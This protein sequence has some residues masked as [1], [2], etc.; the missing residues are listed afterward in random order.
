MGTVCEPAD[1]KDATP[2]AYN[3][4]SGKRIKAPL[5][6]IKLQNLSCSGY[7]SSST[8]DSDNC[9]PRNDNGLLKMSEKGSKKLI[10]HGFIGESQED[11]L[12]ETSVTTRVK[13]GME[14]NLKGACIA[15]RVNNIIGGRQ[16]EAPPDGNEIKDSSSDNYSLSTT[17]IDN[18]YKL[19]NV[20][21][22]STGNALVTKN[23]Y[24]TNNLSTVAGTSQSIMYSIDLGP[25][26]SVSDLDSD[27]DDILCFN[28][29]NF[30]DTKKLEKEHATNTV[31]TPIAGI[32]D[33]GDER[34]TIEV[35]SLLNQTEF[36]HILCQQEQNSGDR[37]YDSD[38]LL[39][40]GNTDTGDTL[41]VTTLYDYGSAKRRPT[42]S[43][44]S[45]PTDS[46][47]DTP[48][49]SLTGNFST[50]YHNGTIIPNKII[51]SSRTDE[52]LIYEAEMADSYFN[53]TIVGTKSNN[54]IANNFKVLSSDAASK[55][56]IH[57]EDITKTISESAGNALK[58]YLNQCESS[59]MF[60]YSKEEAS[61]VN[62]TT[63][64]RD[65]LIHDQ[66]VK[67]KNGFIDESK[68]NRD[69]GRRI[70]SRYMNKIY[71][72]YGN[73][74]ED[75]F[76]LCIESYFILLWLMFCWF[77]F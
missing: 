66:F 56:D 33:N 9:T 55:K 3:R 4:I 69:I 68:Y 23:L 51:S 18:V 45:V 64:L 67:V 49:S 65:P 6:G 75:T 59:R 70:W 48:T 57:G 76:K 25:P 74:E 11:K 17:T 47:I 42:G 38:V 73:I 60:L 22:N 20:E 1:N 40:T 21:I 34:H 7:I 2:Q 31:T 39:E 15:P 12:S 14:L 24:N 36:N 16:V 62:G 27:D 54:S 63:L 13:T 19:D 28:G 71:P 46:G 58:F 10:L 50:E 44:I 52:L 8:T 32:I 61:R 35:N 5:R 37:E 77:C 53:N 26:L 72:G 43:T 41:A 29:N 30:I